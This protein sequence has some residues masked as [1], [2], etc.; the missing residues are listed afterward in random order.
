MI[1]SKITKAQIAKDDA[2]L[3]RYNID[4]VTSFI[5]TLLADLGETY[6]R[7]SI[8][9]LKTLLGSMFPSGLAWNYNGTLKHKIS[10]IYQYILDV[11]RQSVPFGAPG[12]SR[13]PDFFVRSEAL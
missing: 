3:D 4:A 1:E 2:M 12:G 7:S 9:Q 11:D 10:P 5:K 8:S 6:K 13:T